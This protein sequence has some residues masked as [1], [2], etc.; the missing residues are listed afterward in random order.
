M[1]AVIIVKYAIFFLQK[2]KKNY[3]IS[4]DC[5]TQGSNIFVLSKRRRKKTP[6]D[7]AHG[8]MGNKTLNESKFSFDKKTASDI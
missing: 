6:N 2:K 7:T 3:F 8:Q 4:K 1:G 5:D